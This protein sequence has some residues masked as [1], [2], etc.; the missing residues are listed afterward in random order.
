VSGERTETPRGR[1]LLL[2]SGVELARK[3]RDREVSATEVVDAHIERI[4][5]VNPRLNAV[6]VRCY[7]DARRVARDVDRRLAA[8]QPVG[9]LAGVPA[10]VKEL[11]S[12]EGLPNTAGVLARRDVVGTAD[13]PLVAR[14]RQ[15][16]CAIVGLTNVSEAGLWLETHN[17]LYGRTNNAY[18]P[19]HIS[20]GSSGGEGAIIGAGGSPLGIGADIG[21]SIRNPAFFNGICGHKPSGGLLPSI[22]HWP[23]AEGR[24]GRYCVSGPMARRVEDLV[25]LMEV[26]SPEHD[27]YRD[28]ARPRF[29]RLEAP[30]PGEITVH[31]FDDNGLARVSR[32]M[33]AAVAA[34]GDALQ[35]MGMRVERWRPRG[36][37]R[38]AEIWGAKLAETDDMGVRELLGDG[39]P[40]SLLEQ[41]A[42]WPLRRADHPFISLAMAT[43]EGLSDV[44]PERTRKL[45][46]KAD[47]M[48]DEIQ[49]KLG[50]RGVLLCPPYP[51]SAPR[52]RVPLTNP[53]A[54][55]YCGIFNVLEMPSTAV[56]TGFDEG[57][58]PLGVQ[59][60][61][62][63]FNDPLTLW[64]AGRLEE[65]FG[66]WRPPPEL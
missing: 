63:R 16:G 52:H 37:L 5:A 38:S 17:K 60:A 31:V 26:F 41:W 56:P 39:R 2:A 7:E 25:E 65:A 48:Y 3:I 59:V 21:G 40:I 32:S 54:F 34:A 45:C 66:G 58:L 35:R 22:G 62:T 13:A 33:A 43:L 23:P 24:R 28:A 20:G 8:G 4:E 57:G 29:E 15:A 49:A 1:E 53:L 36:L 50:P 30:R 19:D 27:P 46:A 61:S 9:P 55:T 12:V 10:T 6:V 51:R 64:V 11:I 47:A 18:H 44:S 14:L 42:R